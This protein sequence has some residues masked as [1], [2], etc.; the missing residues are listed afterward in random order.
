MTPSNKGTES[1]RVELRSTDRRGRLSPSIISRLLFVEPN[2]GMIAPGGPIL[3]TFIRPL[4]AISG[5]RIASVGGL[6]FV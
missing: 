2:H 4:D 3:V 1:E 6:A 5:V